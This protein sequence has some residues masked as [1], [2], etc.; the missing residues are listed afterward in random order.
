MFTKLLEAEWDKGLDLDKISS[1]FEQFKP[2]DFLL[3]M[4]LVEAFNF[5]KCDVA[6]RTPKF[7]ITHVGDARFIGQWME[8]GVHLG[9]PRYRLIN[10]TQGAEVPMIHWSSKNYWRA[11]IDNRWHVWRTTYYTNPKDTSTP[12]S[13]GWELDQ[14]AEP[15]PTLELKA[16]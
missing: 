11:Y 1:I 4:K 14:G 16:Q 8:Q 3:G 7:S 12:P 2:S 15:A 10:D 13:D 5:P 6:D 9:R